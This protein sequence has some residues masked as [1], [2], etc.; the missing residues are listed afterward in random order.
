MN[1]EDLLIAARTVY[2]E[3]RGEPFEG[4][5][6]VAAVLINR[7]RATDGQWKKDDTLASTCLRH[8]QFSAWNANDPNFKTLQDVQVGT[9][10]TLRECLR[11][12][13]LALDANDPTLG[14]RHYHTVAHP[15]NVRHWPPEWAD[16]ATGSV[17]IGNHIFYQGIP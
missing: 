1:I 16:S 11:A 10:S 8:L 2:G 4:K 15:P 3:A 9:S 17:T 14:A 12:V 6:A 7:W 13:L 5:H